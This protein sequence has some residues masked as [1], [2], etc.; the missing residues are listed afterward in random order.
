MANTTERYITR[1]ERLWL[2]FYGWQ[3]KKLLRE[4]QQISQAAV[5]FAVKHLGATPPSVR[6]RLLPPGIAERSHIKGFWDGFWDGHGRSTAY[7]THPEGNSIDDNVE[8]FIDTAHEIAHPIRAQLWS[9][10]DEYHEAI[11]QVRA[12]RPKAEAAAKKFFYTDLKDLSQL[13]S[14]TYSPRFVCDDGTQELVTF[15][16]DASILRLI[17]PQKDGVETDLLL[18]YGTPFFG[19]DEVLHNSRKLEDVVGSF[20]SL[21]FLVEQKVRP[22]IEPVLRYQRLLDKKNDLKRLDEGWCDFFA[23]VVAQSHGVPVK[24]KHILRGNAQIVK[25]GRDEYVRVAEDVPYIHGFYQLVDLA[26]KLNWDDI[27]VLKE[28]L[29]VDSTEELQALAK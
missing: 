18:W 10:N 26:K 12:A 7:V 11:K 4:A 13:S 20:Q 16:E 6:V 27:A 28:S 5:D 3:N 23:Y 15:S 21:P 14:G 25:I 19:V 9:A 17:C 24:P 1:V 2:P 29:K 22:M 8:S